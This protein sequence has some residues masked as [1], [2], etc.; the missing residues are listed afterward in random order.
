[1]EEKNG[2][3][4]IALYQI[5]VFKV[6]GRL[7]AEAFQIKMGENSGRDQAVRPMQMYDD[8]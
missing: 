4:S 3:Y 6:L 7:K 1:M 8:K 2:F 5:I